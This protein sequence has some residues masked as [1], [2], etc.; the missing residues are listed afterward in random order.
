[1]YTEELYKGVSINVDCLAHFSC[2]R[3]N[4]FYITDQE[5]M[6]NGNTKLNG[7]SQLQTPTFTC[8]QKSYVIISDDDT[9]HEIIFGLPNTNFSIIVS[10]KS[11]KNMLNII[12]GKTIDPITLQEANLS[13]HGVFP[14]ESF[15]YIYM[16]KY[17]QDGKEDAQVFITSLHSK[18][19]YSGYILQKKSFRQRNLIDFTCSAGHTDDIYYIEI[20][21]IQI[22]H[23]GISMT[24]EVS[25]NDMAFLRTLIKN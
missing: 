1:M 21:R 3:Q 16:L 13:E 17:M 24:I 10:K 7:V 23:I 9:E 12:E 18:G 4:H 14:I 6:C 22:Q 11:F 2:N 20:P 8:L 25:Q 5:V 15:S 19:D